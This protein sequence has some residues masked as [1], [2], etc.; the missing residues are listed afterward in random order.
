MKY[1][2]PFALWEG[3]NLRTDSQMG[4]GIGGGGGGK[5]PVH[6]KNF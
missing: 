6:N 3:V 1:A 2:I 4:G 5:P